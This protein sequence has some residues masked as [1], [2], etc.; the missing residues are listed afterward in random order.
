MN[1]TRLL[2]ITSLVSS[3]ALTISPALGQG[4]SPLRPAPASLN[5]LRVTD[6][7]ALDG[8]DRVAPELQSATGSV[9]VVVRLTGQPVA[10]TYAAGADAAE[11]IAAADSIEA[12]QANVIAAAQALDTSA[13]VLGQT[14]NALNAVMLRMD[15][16]K[17]AALAQSP[18]VLSIQPVRNYSFD[19]SEVVPYIGVTQQMRAAGIDGKGVLV[20]VLDSGID[21]T[22]IKLGGDGLESTYAKAYCGDPAAIPDPTDPACTAATLPADPALFPNSKVVGGY[23]FLGETWPLTPDEAPDPNPIDYEG[24][25]THVAD[26]IAGL[27]GGGVG[28]GVAPGA[29][30]LALRVCSAVATSCSGVALLEAMDY[31][32]DPNSDGNL[33]DRAKIINMSLGSDYG[34]AY[35]DD[36]SAAVES[37]SAANVLVVASAGNGSNLPYIAGTPAGAYSALSVAQTQVPGAFQ[38]ALRITAPASIAGLYT[39]TATVPWAPITTGFSGDIA[40][41][42]RGCPAGSVSATSPADPFLANPSGKVALIDRGACSI[43]LKVDNAAKAGATAVIVANNV[44]GTEAPSFSFGG[45][46]TMVQTLIVTQGIGNRIKSAINPGPVSVAVNPA[47]ATPLAGS[48]A[49]TSSRGPSGGQ[50]FYGNSI[51]YGQL[52]KPEIGAPGASVSAVVG[53]GTGTEG[54]GGTS[55]AAPVVSGAAALL[56]QSRGGIMAPSELKSLLMNT[57]ETNVYTVPGALGGSLAPIT[58]IGGG[59]V[60]IDDAVMSQVAAWELNNRGAA[61]SFG[62]VDVNRPV[63]TLR[64]TVVVKNYSTSTVKFNITPS[65]RFADDQASG[66]VHVEAPASITVNGGREKTFRVQITIDASK[67]SLWQL[68]SGANGGNGN[69]LNGPEVDGYVSLVDASGNSAN[70][71][72]LPWHVL[73]RLADNV[74]ANRTSVDLNTTVQGLPAGTLRLRNRGAGTAA[75]DA[76]ELL[77]TSSNLSQNGMGLPPVIDLKAVGVATFADPSCGTEGWLM[78]FAISSYYRQ[79]HADAQAAFN[80]DL[81]IN[82]DGKFDFEIYNSDLATSG[83]KSGSNV[84]WAYNLRTGRQTAFFFTDHPLESSNY[85]LTVCESQITDSAIG[86]APSLG[87]AMDMQVYAQELQFAGAVTDEINDLVVVPGGER[88]VAAVNDIAPGATETMTVID[89]GA[90]AN[91]SKGVLLLLDAYRTAGR[92]GGTDGNDS[93]VIT[94]NK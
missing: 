80:I 21:Y 57:A 34:V 93:L 46:D 78:Q 42:G 3:L 66:V 47:D 73:P 17:I 63:I 89:F 25:G 18:G 84:T 81:D 55:G 75:I 39:A 43:S 82:R 70:N 30:L 37:A 8:V 79:S 19:L 5:S 33:E 29:E 10:Y 77:G 35:H 36:L 14:K 51:M 53:T 54:F 27:P 41:I 48:M 26:I 85:V 50:M 12:A 24:H 13:V 64:R 44:A 92:V 32:L 90:S 65:F 87:K 88:Y 91:T 76:Y 69:L 15:A 11:Q 40:Y 6:Q 22:H 71:I 58:R 59:E 45:G 49:S 83:S 62:F 23:D 52:I 16:S 94:V 68:D 72:H 31:A 56:L 20:A 28:S 2:M 7:A 86:L 1:K 9:R 74:T 38:Y 4:S 61:L 60:R 67:L